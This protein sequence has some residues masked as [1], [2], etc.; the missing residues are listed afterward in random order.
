MLSILV[1]KLLIWLR[2]IQRLLSILSI[3]LKRLEVI[4]YLIVMISVLGSV[5]TGKLRII[6]HEWVV[7]RRSQFY[8][9][10]T[11]LSILSLL[12]YTMSEGACILVWALYWRVHIVVLAF[13]SL[14]I[15]ASTSAFTSQLSIA[16]ELRY[17]RKS[18]HAFRCLTNNFL[19]FVDILRIFASLVIAVVIIC[20]RLLNKMFWQWLIVVHNFL[21]TMRK[22]TMVSKCTTLIILIMTASDSLILM[23]ISHRITSHVRLKSTTWNK[24]TLIRW[25][26]HHEHWQVYI[27]LS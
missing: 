26:L 10:L 1:I 7:I 17:G 21:V 19:N 4:R 16:L 9:H 20:H 8:V 13:D 12:V 3:V 6:G 11:L 14:V 22:C 15:R 24:I 23:I 2:P 18:C 25:L 27:A 5:A